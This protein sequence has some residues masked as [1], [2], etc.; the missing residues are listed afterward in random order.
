M[1]MDGVR[2]LL[3]LRR[4]VTALRPAPTVPTDVMK[5]ESKNNGVVEKAL[6]TWEGQFRTPTSHIELE[7][8]E[9]IPKDHPALRCC[10]WSAA[11]VVN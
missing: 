8:D 7:L 3:Q 2:E 4:E 5:K 11:Q 6:Q 9:A 10:I 1:I